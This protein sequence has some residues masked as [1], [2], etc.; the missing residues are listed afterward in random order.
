MEIGEDFAQET[1]K[2]YPVTQYNYKRVPNF[3]DGNSVAFPQNDL[4][5]VKGITDL[6]TQKLEI[7]APS[8]QPQ[9][10]QII[11]RCK[12]MGTTSSLPLRVRDG[13]DS[14]TGDDGDKRPKIP[15]PRYNTPP[16]GMSHIRS[17][18]ESGIRPRTA[19]TTNRERP[20]RTYSSQ[21]P[22]PRPRQNRQ[23]QQGCR[24]YRQIAAKKIEVQA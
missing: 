14:P 7:A 5:G 16:S 20:P 1:E 22:T 23:Q 6:A 13:F 4:N 3:L 2:S 18:T 12:V 19:A 15:S 8:T 9:H 21:L 10:R 17:E 11:A 24:T